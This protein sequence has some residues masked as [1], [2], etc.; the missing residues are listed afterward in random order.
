MENTMMFLLLKDRLVLMPHRKTVSRRRFLLASGGV[1]SIGAA[2]CL[3]DDDEITAD[4][5][6]DDDSVDD[7]DDPDGLTNV[8]KAQT[9]W[10][11]V[12]EHP[13][14]DDEDVRNESYVEMEEA[15]R[16]DMILLPLFHGKSERFSY[17]WVDMPE[18]GPLGSHH[19]QYHNVELDTGHEHKDENVFEVINSTVTT[20]DPIQSTDTASSVV[21]GQVYECLTTYPA[22]NLELENQLADDVEISDDLLTYT[23]HIK[24]GVQF[25][26][27]EELT[28]ADFKYAWRRVAESPGSRRASF[29]L[30]PTHL[31]LVAETDE[32]EGVGPANVVPD[33]IAFE[34]IDDHTFEIELTDPTPGALDILS[35]DAFAAVPEGYVDD[36]EDYD[37]EVSQE[38]VSSEAMRGTGPFEFV[39]WSPGDEVSVTRF[40]DYHEGQPIP[41]AVH[42]IILEDADAIW[43]YINERNADAFGIPTAHYDRDLVDAEEDDMGREVGT[44]A[45]LDNGDEVNYVAV[46]DIST[47]YFAFNGGQTITAARQ[48]VAYATD[49]EE[50]VDLVFEGRGTVAFSFTPPDLWP[51][52]VISYDDWVDEWPYSPNETD[53]A[54]ANEV[55]AEAG[56]DEDDPYELEITT[57]D[58]PTFQEAAALTRDKLAGSGMEFEI[59]EAQFADLIASGHDGE[60]QAFSLGWIWSWQD[61]AYGMF[62]FEPAN[63]NTDLIPEQA[64]G[65]YLDWEQVDD[66]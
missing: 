25:H 22:G 59:R 20:L 7:D 45:E 1:A 50:L 63:T 5:T 23:F 6:A 55:L 3:G 33:S 29:L 52:E 14:P 48:A 58:D 57:Y 4:D 62:G 37:G 49:H 34:V 54:S 11:R 47:F 64:D 60:L 15:I 61:I 30:S 66:E 13:H 32:D 42:W 41:E 38:E 46:S 8:E 53:I 18:M 43:T 39:A 35:Y 9:A 51:E 65:Y 56:Y 24:E 31:G 2:G 26:D 21:I 27:G 16:D 36:L 10:D 12:V 44:Y 19:Q 28:A 17:E 40:D